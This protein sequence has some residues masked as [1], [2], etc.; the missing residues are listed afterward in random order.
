MKPKVAKK[1]LLATHGGL[2]LELCAAWFNVSP[3]SVYRLL[4]A[5]GRTGLVTFLTRCYLS[6]P[7]YFIV[8]DKH[9]H[10]NKERVYLPTIVCGRVIWHLSYTTGK[11]VE[12]FFTVSLGKPLSL[13][14]HRLVPKESSLMAFRVLA[15]V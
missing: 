15:R 6:L 11:S 3:M 7:D 2:S 13:V 14:T 12:A 10:C 1:V 8:D 4:C 5:F 9:T